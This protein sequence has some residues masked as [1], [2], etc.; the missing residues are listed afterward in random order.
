MP[1]LT[2]AGD[3]AQETG[4]KCTRGSV[5]AADLAGS[6]RARGALTRAWVQHPA[7]SCRILKGLADPSLD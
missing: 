7:G 4:G 2:L 5:R 3:G 6:C 1:G